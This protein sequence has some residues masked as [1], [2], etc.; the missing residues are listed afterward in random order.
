MALYL[1]ELVPS[2]H[3]YLYCG[4]LVTESRERKK[5]RYKSNH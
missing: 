4:L 1:P 5:I 3:M 2:A